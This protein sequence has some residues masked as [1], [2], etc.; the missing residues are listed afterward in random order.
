VMSVVPAPRLLWLVLAAALLAVPAG[1]LPDLV[2]LWLLTLGVL[3]LA[4]LADVV[5]SLAK[6]RPLTVSTEPTSRFSKDREGKIQVTFSQPAGQSRRLRFALA[7]PST[8]ESRE[9]QIWVDL[10]ADAARAR[11]DWACTPRERGRFTNVV[12][13]TE[14]ASPFG[15]W[16][17]RMRTVVPGELRVYPNLFAERRQLAALFFARGESGSTAQRVVGRGRDFEKLRDYLPGDS[18]DEIHWKAT[19]KRGRPVTKIFQAERTQE[20][21]VIVDTSRLSARPAT[22]RTG[23]QTA[24]ERYLTAALML[25]LAAEQQGDRFGLITHDD[26]VRLFLRA[27][28]GPAHYAACREAALGLQSSEATPDMAEIV[29]H[30]RAGLRRRAL[31]FFLTDLTD[32]VLAEDFTKHVRLLAR[33]HLV[34]VSQLRDPAVAP[35]FSAEAQGDD[36]I[37]AR[38]AGHERW[39]ETRALGKKLKPLG[40][41]M[42]TL[43]N[44]TMA[45]QLVTQYLQVKRR[46]AL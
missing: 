16:H 13:C 37:Y 42:A 17:L 8:F 26:R 2:P 38:L 1:P 19:A 36:E 4:A 11:I 12:A 18:F 32:P 46:Q 9:E 20:I 10:P 28:R 34:L 21:Y 40:V 35:L 6:A 31:L 14:T 45:A 33:Q 44:E 5:V 41:T 43:E 7:L 23:T 15:L 29:R 30:L 39:T 24:L 22:N 3:V 27:S 25:L